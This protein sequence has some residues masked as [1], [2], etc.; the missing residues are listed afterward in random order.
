MIATVEKTE[1]Q[2]TWIRKQID[3]A[4]ALGISTTR[5]YQLERNPR[6]PGK[7]Q[8]G[9]HLPSWL[10]FYRSQKKKAPAPVSKSK[11]QKSGVLVKTYDDLRIEKLEEEIADK[12]FKRE[13]DQAQWILKDDV[14]ASLMKV[15]A[16]VSGE[17]SR[18]IR[19]AP[20]HCSGKSPA[21]A[22]A[23][24]REFV[25]DAVAVIRKELGG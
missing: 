9:Y 19:E 21:A 24:A 18:L 1:S 12:K 3:L 2:K 8:R 10:K 6:C 14:S 11:A 4:A 25:D 16:M 23:W 17:F 15:A 7:R 20:T 5:I 13:K 22:R